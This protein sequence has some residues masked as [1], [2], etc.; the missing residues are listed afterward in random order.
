MSE[1]NTSTY[2]HDY[3]PRIDMKRIRLKS[4]QE[5]QHLSRAPSSRQKCLP[6][7]IPIRYK[8][9]LTINQCLHRQPN[10]YLLSLP[11]N[12]RLLYKKLKVLT[13]DDMERSRNF[14]KMKST[15][16]GHAKEW[17]EG[18]YK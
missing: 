14:L 16:H 5:A 11:Y 1:K 3:Y 18:V 8:P 10:R 17:L 12:N 2:T 13:P 15:Y 4:I 6:D 7:P 9:V